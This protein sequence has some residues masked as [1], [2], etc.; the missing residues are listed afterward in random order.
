MYLDVKFVC[1]VRDVE[2][3]EKSFEMLGVLFLLIFIIVFCFVFWLL[4][5]LWY[6]FDFIVSVRR[7]MGNLFGE[8]MI[9]MWKMYYV[10]EKL[11]RESIFEDWFVFVLVKDGWE[12]LCWVLD[13]F[14]L[15]GVLFLKV[16][17]VKVV[18]ELML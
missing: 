12:L 7:L 14:V 4:L 13:M 10:Y 2:V 5:M 8:D 1:L 3:W 15:E 18:D 11:L 6:F 16:N 17:D 9:C